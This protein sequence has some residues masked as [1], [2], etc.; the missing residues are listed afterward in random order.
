MGEILEIASLTCGLQR[1][2]EKCMCLTGWALPVL[3]LLLPLA[4]LF[5][6]GGGGVI[7][8]GQFD[9]GPILPLTPA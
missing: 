3:L 6:G 8:Q 7:I 9:E 2:R 5:F 4:P 1:R